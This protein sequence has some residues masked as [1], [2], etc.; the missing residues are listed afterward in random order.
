[1]DTLP[2]PTSEDVLVPLLRRARAGDERARERLLAALH[3]PMRDYVAAR[4]RST[5]DGGDLADDVAQEALIRIA[6]RLGSCRATTDRQ[7]FKWALTVARSR[8][9]DHLRRHGDGWV[10]RIGD[11]DVAAPLDAKESLAPASATFRG[12]LQ[13]VVRELPPSTQALL[14]LRVE[15]GEPWAE[16]ARV[17]RTTTA[18][19]KRRYQR[20]QARLRHAVEQRVAGLPPR[21]RAELEERLRRFQ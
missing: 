20:A 21:S 5:P 12:V 16:V 19:A 11:H 15:N 9:L 13:W 4:T 14:E 8:L 17:L 1:M 3:V 10:E 7:L 2:D 6:T 18:G